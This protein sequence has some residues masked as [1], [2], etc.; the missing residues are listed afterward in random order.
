MPLQECPLLAAANAI[1]VCQQTYDSRILRGGWAT[2]NLNS[3]TEVLRD[4]FDAIYVGEAEHDSI[5][6]AR[7][8]SCAV[9]YVYPRNHGRHP[10]SEL[11][12]RSPE[13]FNFSEGIVVKPELLE[14]DQICYAWT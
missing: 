2:I 14:V 6:E 11:D 4:R 8:Y 1:S 12:Y 9:V 3:V 10:I 13:D 7:R 5:Y